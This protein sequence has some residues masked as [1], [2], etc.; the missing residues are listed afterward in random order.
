MQMKLFLFRYS[1]HTVYEQSYVSYEG[2]EGSFMA[3]NSIVY[4]LTIDE[5]QK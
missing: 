3:Q 1:H 4:T 2:K 5:L